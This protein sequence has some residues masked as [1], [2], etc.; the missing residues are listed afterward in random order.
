MAVSIA[1][2]KE[3]SHDHTHRP[4]TRPASTM[5]AP[6]SV[7]LTSILAKLSLQVGR[8]GRVGGAAGPQDRHTAGSEEREGGHGAGRMGGRAG[9]ADGGG[10]GRAAAKFTV[11]AMA[12]AAMAVAAIDGREDILRTVSIVIG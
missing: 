9:S 8:P 1:S 7:N 5:C 11:V 10:G 6:G 2:T 4:H 12:V 3:T